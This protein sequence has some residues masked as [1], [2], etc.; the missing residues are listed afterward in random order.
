MK[1]VSGLSINIIPPLSVLQPAW[2][3]KGEYLQKSIFSV[4]MA[5]DISMLSHYTDIE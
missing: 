2:A 5:E 3:I 1:T 4:F